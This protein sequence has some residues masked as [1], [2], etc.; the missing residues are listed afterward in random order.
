[1]FQYSD[2]LIFQH[3]AECWNIIFGEGVWGLIEKLKNDRMI[4]NRIAEIRKK[5]I[6]KWVLKNNK[7]KYV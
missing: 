3:S 1:V 6:K 7:T 5:W 4:K 2:I